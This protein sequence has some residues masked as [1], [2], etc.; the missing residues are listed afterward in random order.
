MRVLLTGAD[1]Y[2]GVRMGAVLLNRGFDV[3]GLDSGFHR[4]GWLYH[5]AERRPEVITMDTR[6]VTVDDLAG[7]DAVVHCAEI[8]NDP[9]GDLNPEI[10]YKIN[11]HGT[12]GLAQ[13]AKQAGVER[14]VHMSSC[15]VYGATG[16]VDH[17]EHGET[18]PLTAYA[19][20]KLL[21]EQDVA[22]L[23]DDSFS[24]TFMRNATA[25][26]A[27]PRQRFDIV[28]NN[29]AGWAWT[30]REIRMES[31][32]TP[33][34]PFVHILD[35]AKAV[36]CVLDADRDLVHNEIY[37]VGDNRSNYQIREIA[38]I[39]SAAVPGCE[40]SVGDSSHDKRNYRADFTKI[41]SKLPGFS[42]DWDVEKGATELVEV[43]ERIGLSSAEFELRTH[44]RLKQIKYLLETGQ[45]DDDFFWVG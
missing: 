31:D 27:S 29:L 40:L 13:K 38:Q 15:S 25:Y 6:H 43:F 12:V 44:T 16:E 14:F 30:T 20:C 17:D 22:P 28:V 10:T 24:P 5:S 36:A 9:V 21:V 39:I 42:C 32:G 4:G 37:N 26:G 34:R 19:K 35:I 33:W 23:A 41:N 3:V 45:I 11:H 18:E 2:I 1:G 8:S 7:F